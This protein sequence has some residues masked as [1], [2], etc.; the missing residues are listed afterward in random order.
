MVISF[1]IEP[2]KLLEFTWKN[3]NSSILSKRPG[4]GIVSQFLPWNFFWLKSNP[5][6]AFSFVP[7]NVP[8]RIPLNLQVSLVFSFQLLAY[9]VGS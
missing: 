3:V 9:P 2:E 5:A 1:G 6:T 4:K 8:Q 7:G